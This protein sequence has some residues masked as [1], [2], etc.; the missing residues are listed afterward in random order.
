MLRSIVLLLVFWL[1]QVFWGK[2]T[3]L[4][5]QALPGRVLVQLQQSQQPMDV[6]NRWEGSRWRQEEKV[7][8]M[9]NAWLLLSEENN[10]ND[11]EFLRWL[12]R[13]PEVLA[14]QF[15]HVIA[16]RGAVLDSLILPNDPLFGQQWQLFNTGQNGGLPG[17]DLHG[18]SAWDLSTSGLTSAGDP[19]V[20]AVIDGGLAATHPDLVQNLWHNTAEIPGD[21]IDNDNNGYVDDFQGW[22]VYQQNDNLAGIST[23]H[24]T[25]VSGVIAADGNNGIGVTG[26]NWNAKLMFVAGKGQESVLLQAFDYVWKQR[27]RYNQTNGAEGALVVALNCSWGINYGLPADAPLWCAAFDSL[28]QA[29]IL[30]ICATANLPVNVDEVGDLPSTCPSQY[31]IAVTSLDHNDLK[32]P[33]AAWGLQHVDLGAYGA[34]VFTISGN[35][36]YGYQYGTS[37]AAPQVCGAVGLLY[38]ADCPNLSALAKTNPNA[39]AL[40]AR[41][42][43]LENTLPNNS[44]TGLVSSSGRL[45]L[46]KPVANYQDNC[47]ACPAPFALS[48]AMTTA[49]VAVLSWVGLPSYSSVNLRWRKAGDSNWNLLV[50]VLSPFILSNLEP[51]TAYEFSVRANCGPIGASNWSA[52]LSFTTDGCCMAPASI[53]LLNTTTE[54]ADFTWTN[55][56]AAVQYELRIRIGIGPWISYFTPNNSAVIN[57]L[58]PCTDYEVQVRSNCD[59]ATTLF[60]TSL[61]FET[62]GC[63]ACKDLPYCASSAD[64]GWE[65]W[66]QTLNIGSWLYD[67][68]NSQG[69]QDLSGDSYGLPLSLWPETLYPVEITPGFSG[70]AYKQFY[71]IFIDYNG[72]GAFEY[73]DELA[74]DPGFATESPAIGEIQTPAFSI[75]GLVRMRV[76]MKYQTPFNNPPLPCENFKAGEVEDYCVLLQ[77]SST[78][79]SSPGFKPF[80]LKIYPSPAK[81]HAFVQ[82]T[83]VIENRVNLKIWD[84]AGRLCREEALMLSPSGMGSVGLLGLPSGVYALQIFDGEHLWQGKVLVE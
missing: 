23:A 17:A 60:S 1:P 31:L 27:K 20:L 39:A 21:G 11:A 57:S 15:D 54:S 16:D 4:H 83:P 32:A 38:G 76:M 71:R 3:A 34:D 45:D 81:D 75:E 35:A 78:G 62:P 58:A 42:I 69:Y 37:Y 9:L 49:S 84:A 47:S 25:S 53:T 61:F 24:G 19:I 73:P 79:A 28:G 22:N 50:G 12:N 56:T 77:S 64:S 48:V 8:E 68:G 46:F 40:W 10:G 52:D 33:D 41:E 7:S 44:L 80:A 6:L 59:T 5:A 63:G 51:C 29:G 14:T 74:F 36:G 55:V 70:L 2:T 43:L 13:Q 82:T 65:E 30:S 72:N 18:P 66:I 26:V 67:S